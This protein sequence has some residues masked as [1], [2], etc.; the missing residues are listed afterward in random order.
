MRHISTIICAAILAA[1][2]TV[3]TVLA[4]D[5]AIRLIP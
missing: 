1:L 3:V 5:A 4:Y 2:Y